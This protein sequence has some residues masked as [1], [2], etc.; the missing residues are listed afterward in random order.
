[1]DR[2]TLEGVSDD[3]VIE[4]DP[5]TARFSGPFLSGDQMKS[6]LVMIVATQK[7]VPVPKATGGK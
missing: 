4:A 2:R 1:M 3:T 5:M 6:I 7:G